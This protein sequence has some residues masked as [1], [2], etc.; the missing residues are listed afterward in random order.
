MTS[1]ANPSRLLAEDDEE[2][3]DEEVDEEP[4]QARTSSAAAGAGAPGSV[5][6]A[7]GGSLGSAKVSLP[8]SAVVCAVFEPGLAPTA[9]RDALT[10]VEGT[11]WRPHHL[12][13]PMPAVDWPVP[14]VSSAGA[15]LCHQAC[16]EAKT[17]P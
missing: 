17:S 5:S 7:V 3:D 11:V 1:C 12:P 16:Q 2:D 10:C 14:A 6:S 13:F 4:K 9:S 15:I 8:C